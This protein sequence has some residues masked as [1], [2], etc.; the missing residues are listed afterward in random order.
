MPDLMA[1]GTGGRAA[2]L[3]SMLA[4]LSG[5][6][7]ATNVEDSL[8]PTALRLPESFAHQQSG[9]PFSSCFTDVS[10]QYSM[11]DNV[12]TYIVQGNS[13]GILESLNGWRSLFKTGQEVCTPE[14]CWRFCRCMSRVGMASEKVFRRTSRLR[15]LKLPP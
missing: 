3:A 9:C 11:P 12:L 10:K 6:D 1:D 5:F 14:T 2:S 8:L 13:S 4:F 15:T 7:L